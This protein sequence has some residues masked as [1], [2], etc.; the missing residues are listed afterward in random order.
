M[1]ITAAAC[2]KKPFHLKRTLVMLR[3]NRVLA[4]IMPV[5]FLVFLILLFAA[6]TGGDFLEPVNLRQIL[7]QALITG[8]VATGAAFIFGTG[9]INIAM[10]SCTALTCTVAAKVYLAT[11]SVPAMFLTAIAF[12][13]VLMLCCVLI[14]T[15]LHVRVMFVTIVMMVLLS[16]IHEELLGG[17]NITLPFAMTGALQQSGAMYILFFS[18]LIFCIVLFH[19]TWVGRAIK[20]TGSNPVCAEQTGIFRNTCLLIAFL[21]AG[22]GVGCGALVTIIRSGSITSST[23]GDLNMNCM[24]AIVLGGMPVFGGSKSR[25]YAAVIGAVTVTTLSTGLLMVG[26]SSTVLQGVR[27]VIF[28]L[29]VLAGNKRPQL[30][31]TREG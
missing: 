22:L 11:N 3:E 21:V 10:G 4:Q 20:M 28:L 25:A 24:L 23:C 12:G 13:L 27:G 26:V 5:A 15:A 6:L 18:F 14:S 8:T 9:N 19:G 17:V 2:P 16:K 7:D 30:L 31:P 1:S 29:L